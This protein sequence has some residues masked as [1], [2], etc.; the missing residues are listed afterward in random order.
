MDILVPKA[1]ER[2][3]SHGSKRL[4]KV[5]EFLWGVVKHAALVIGAN[6]K[7]SH[8]VLFCSGDGASVFLKNVVPVEIHVIEAARGTDLL[9]EFR[10]SMG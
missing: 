8:V 1:K 5:H 4:G 7:D 6:D 10:R 3:K 2:V 9:D